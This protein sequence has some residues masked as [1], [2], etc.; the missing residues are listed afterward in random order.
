MIKFVR[1]DK[2]GDT[3]SATLLNLDWV[4]K[5][6]IFNIANETLPENQRCHINFVSDDGFTLSSL[7]FANGEEAHH[8]ILEHL[9]VTL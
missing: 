4:A 8:W 6:E 5:I 3:A 2:A 9:N 7:Y 1:I